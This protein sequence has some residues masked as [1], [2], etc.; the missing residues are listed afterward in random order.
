MNL[1]TSLKAAVVSAFMFGA[2]GAANAA[3]VVDQSNI[4][5]A[6]SGGSIIYQ[7]FGKPI[8]T[9][10]IGTVPNFIEAQ[11]IQFV[12]AGIS[13]VLA[14]IDLQLSRFNPQNSVGGFEVVIA[15]NVTFDNAGVV[16]SGNILGSA[17]ANLSS[18]AAGQ[19]GIVNFDLSAQNI[20]FNAGEQFVIAVRNPERIP[21]RLRLGHRHVHGCPGCAV[22]CR[23]FLTD[24]LCGRQCLSRHG[25]AERAGHLVQVAR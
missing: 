21:G 17:F 10:P 4:A 16:Q 13:G 9:N 15:N 5:V 22:Q 18:L 3:V 20:S 23:E 6:P 7:I 11:G 8:N 19:G 14:A 1:T 12:T 24:R 2:V 25:A